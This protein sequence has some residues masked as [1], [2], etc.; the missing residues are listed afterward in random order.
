MNVLLISPQPFFTERGTPIAV[1]C[2]AEALC[3]DG[4]RVDL[5]TYP[6]GDDVAIDGLAIHR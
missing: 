5:L 4:H 3:A 2:L 6:F 1:R